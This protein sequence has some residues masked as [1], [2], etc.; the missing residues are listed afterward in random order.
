MCRDC[1]SIFILEINSPVMLKTLCTFEL[2]WKY[3]IVN[4][5]PISFT[6]RPYSEKKFGL[7]KGF[8]K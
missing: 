7:R 2:L 4:I 8:E 6:T 1:C 3:S 5:G